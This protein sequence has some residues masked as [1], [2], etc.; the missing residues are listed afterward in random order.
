MTLGL[1]IFAWSVVSLLGALEARAEAY[2]V[3]LVVGNNQGLP[4]EIGLRYAEAD[5]RRMARVLT[6]L[7]G[8]A[9]NRVEVL[10]GETA[11]VVQKRLRALAKAVDEPRTKKRLVF[12]YYSGHSDG[13]YLHLS[14]TR[15]SVL[16]LRRSL[17]ADPS[18]MAVAVVDSCQSGRMIRAKG[19]RPGP[20]FDVHLAHEA[21][22]EGSVFIS[23][24]NENE[25]AQESDTL[26]GSF[27]THHWVSGLYGAADSNRDDLVTL[28]EAYRYARFRTIEATIAS[29]AG[30]QHPSYGVDL[31]GQG[32]V[33]L[34]NLS[35][36]TAEIEI[37]GSGTSAQVF[38][39]D[40]ARQLVLTELEQ[41]AGRSAR[42]RLPPGRYTI[43]KR[44]GDVLHIADVHARAGARAQV[45]P[46][47]MRSVQ[48]AEREAKGLHH[49]QRSAALKHTLGVRLGVRTPLAEGFGPALE[50]RL[51]Y[52]AAVGGWYVEP[53]LALRLANNADRGQLEYDIGS[54]AGL[55][56]RWR[57]FRFEAG[58]DVGLLLFER[59]R[60]LLPG[61][62]PNDG[63]ETTPGGVAAPAGPDGIPLG[64]EPAPAPQGVFAL[65]VQGAVTTGVAYELSTEL[66]AALHAYGGAAI[67]KQND[68]SR[69]R[70]V[71]GVGLG[72]TY[73]F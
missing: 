49:V 37:E 72:V 50:L 48:L 11:T 13:E 70:P 27:F 8:F 55:L 29:R 14:G 62:D 16:E 61:P 31:A 51:G 44:E 41:V 21:G 57:Q 56:W 26:E 63:M 15:L 40:Q 64:I 42:I 58:V 19:A 33:V 18:A 6:D 69:Q 38:V 36:A 54:G 47:S 2:R 67:F 46:S 73:N 1:P 28:D 60:R 4:S 52:R 17:T 43:R 20:A 23:S 10:L 68:R 7:G 25:I 24:S 32:S 39:L 53:R 30:V 35:R 59:T 45:D 5:A 22:L 65:G 9:S 34:A 12:F 3:A 66:R 71:L